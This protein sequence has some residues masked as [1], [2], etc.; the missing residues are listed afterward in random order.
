MLS[1]KIL[2]TRYRKIRFEID[3]EAP[4]PADVK[5]GQIHCRLPVILGSGISA[6][7]QPA[8]TM[9]S[10]TP[11]RLEQIEP[12]TVIGSQKHRIP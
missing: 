11:K 5:V 6:T 7:T 9:T 3:G 8:S 12:L 4:S 2:A 10:S 1:M